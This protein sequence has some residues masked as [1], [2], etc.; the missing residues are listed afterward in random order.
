LREASRHELARFH[1]HAAA[2]RVH[3]LNVNLL[4]GL[5]VKMRAGRSDGWVIC[6]IDHL[7][8]DAETL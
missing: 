8:R 7:A 5:D 1:D 6:L 3:D 2:G 4:L